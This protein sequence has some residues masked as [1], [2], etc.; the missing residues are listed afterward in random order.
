MPDT[1]AAAIGARGFLLDGKWTTE[2]RLVEVRSPFDQK[3]V[4]TVCFAGRPQV[5][6]AIAAATR[7][8]E[9]TRKLPAYER[10]RVLRGVSQQIAERR[11]EFACCIALED[12]KSTRL[13][14]SHSR[15]SR[16]PSSA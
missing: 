7:A 16:M 6:P 10:Q 3:V 13:N 11:E 15:A 4:G 2:G 5:A 1:A 8:F 12:R 9:V 14:S